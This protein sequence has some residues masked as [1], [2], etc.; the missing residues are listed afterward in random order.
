MNVCYPV[1]FGKPAIGRLWP[2]SAP[3]P[4]A[5]HRRLRSVAD[6]RPIQ[7]GNRNGN[8]FRQSIVGSLRNSMSELSSDCAQTP[9]EL[10]IFSTRQSVPRITQ[11][12]PEQPFWR[13][14]LSGR[15][16]WMLLGDA[17]LETK[18]KAAIRPSLEVWRITSRHS[19][20]IS[21]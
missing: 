17:G 18:V 14:R 19:G 2:G 5:H 12:H 15:W 3:I 4:D 21:P 10:G 7:S 20:W 8:I 6:I 9:H 1:N 13:D 11:G 16:R